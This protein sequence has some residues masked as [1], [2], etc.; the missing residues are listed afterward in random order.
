MRKRKELI[1]TS[2]DPLVIATGQV[3]DK[4]SEARVF[5]NLGRHSAALSQ[6]LAARDALEAAI[7]LASGRA[8]S[9]PPAPTET[10]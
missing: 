8:H 6:L 7:N 4:V 3:I 2:A 9:P 10:P 1:D 5:R